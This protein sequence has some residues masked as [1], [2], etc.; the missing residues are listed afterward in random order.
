MPVQ[1][2]T[3]TVEDKW[4][5]TSLRIPYADTDRM[6][7]VYYANYLV[8]F[9]CARTE[10][11][12]EK[13]LTYRKFEEMGYG[14]PVAEAHVKYRGRIFYDDMIRVYARA[15]IVGHTRIKFEYEILDESGQE[16]LAEGYSLHAVIDMKNGKVCRIPQVLIDLTEK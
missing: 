2:E 6:E 13:G 12:R 5:I 10:W 15:S 8:Y 7:H 1:P 11:M 3:V 4:V 14:V 16:V 9:E